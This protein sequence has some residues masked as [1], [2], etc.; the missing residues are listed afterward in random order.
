MSLLH[1]TSSQHH[2]DTI[3]F[4]KVHSPHHHPDVVRVFHRRRH[5]FCRQTKNIFQAGPSGWHISSIPFH[6]PLSLYRSSPNG[7]PSLQPPYLSRKQDPLHTKF[8][9][10][11]F[12]P[13]AAGNHCSQKER[14]T[15]RRN[16]MLSLTKREPWT[17][18]GSSVGL[19]NWSKKPWRVRPHKHGASSSI[20][21]VPSTSPESSIIHVY[22]KSTLLPL[23]NANSVL[24]IGG[25]RPLITCLE[26]RIP[27]NPTLHA[28]LNRRRKER[29]EP[30]I[31]R[32]RL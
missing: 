12:A 15:E 10:T 14:L 22:I 31:K 3:L 4:K 8:N 28:S 11:T 5:R 21:H 9:S 26:L 30:K 18:R 17:R 29:A 13:Q 32:N 7:S 2:P 25:I 19:A 1:L 27:P 23:V 20:L 24:L 16:T 6:S